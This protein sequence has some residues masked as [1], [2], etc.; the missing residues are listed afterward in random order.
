MYITHLLSK[1][2]N[3]KKLYYFL[4]AKLTGLKV[5]VYFYNFNEFPLEIKDSKTLSKNINIKKLNSLYVL[6]RRKNI[7]YTV[8]FNENP[9]YFKI[10]LPNIILSEPIHTSIKWKHSNFNIL[11]LYRNYPLKL[12]AKINKSPDRDIVLACKTIFNNIEN[13]IIK[14]DQKTRITEEIVKIFPYI[15]KINKKILYKI[16]VIKKSVYKSYFSRNE[17]D[18]FREILAKNSKTIKANIEILNIYDKFN[19]EAYS[20]IK[21]D[22]NTKNLA[23]Y[24]NDKLVKFE[25]DKMYYLIIGARRDNKAVVKALAN[26]ENTTDEK[27]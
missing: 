19:V 17:M 11:T 15:R 2:I 5:S 24:L 27:I 18:N 25:Q 22:H 21:Q 14:I 6:I 20:S 12:S 16:P 26:L 7:E 23:C 1:E 8:K 9:E 4:V 10:K 13:N 3:L